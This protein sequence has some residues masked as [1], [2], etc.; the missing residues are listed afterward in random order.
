MIK[1]NCIEA[2]ITI[3]DSI[4]ELKIIWSFKIQVIYQTALK[5]LQNQFLKL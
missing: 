3:S 1:I 2:N 4:S 5:K